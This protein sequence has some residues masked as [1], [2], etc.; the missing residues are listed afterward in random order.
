MKNGKY[1]IQNVIQRTVFGPGGQ[2]TEVLEVNVITSKGVTFTQ[3]FTK[4]EY[5]EDNVKTKL[6]KE[7]D[8]HNKIMEL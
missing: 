4:D 5:T 2:A 1:E 6:G 7:A 8:L 3:Q